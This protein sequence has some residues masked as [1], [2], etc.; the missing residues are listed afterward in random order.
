MLPER[1]RFPTRQ[2]RDTIG[3]S[4]QGWNGQRREFVV[5]LFNEISFLY[6]GFLW[7]T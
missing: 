4:E 5:G 1:D 7:G 3:S 6:A 2:G